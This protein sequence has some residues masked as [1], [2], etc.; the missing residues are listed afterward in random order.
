MRCFYFLLIIIF[1]CKNQHTGSR[2]VPIENISVTDVNPY[3]PNKKRYVLN[4]FE[5]NLNFNTSSITSVWWRQVDGPVN[6]L[7]ECASCYRTTVTGLNVPGIY[8]YEFTV[9]DDVGLTGKDT[10]SIT[11]YSGA[12]PVNKLAIDVQKFDFFNKLKIV[13]DTNQQVQ[14]QVESSKDGNSFT[15]IGEVKFQ[16]GISFYRDDHYFATTCYR[17]K[18]IDNA[19][20]FSYSNIVCINNVPATDR[21]VTYMV[22]SYLTLSYYSAS[23]QPCEISVISINGQVIFP[24]Q[25]QYMLTGLNRFQFL[26]SGHSAGMYSIIIKTGGQIISKPFFCKKI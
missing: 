13:Y 5:T 20:K 7:I 6:T 12:L 2:S 8:R 15:K 3:L 9:T 17:V 26:M 19:G 14:L 22:G 24:S 25:K 10:C 23:D 1:S 11:V 16:D 4:A 21:I 18:Q